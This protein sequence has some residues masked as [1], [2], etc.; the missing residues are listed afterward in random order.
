MKNFLLIGLFTVAVSLF[1]TG[2]AQFLP[3]LENRP[4]A[5][6]ALGSKIGP[7]E[8]SAIGAGVFDANCSQCHKLGE[9]GR[10]PDLNGMGPRAADR[11]AERSAESGQTFTDIDYLVEA[12]CKPGDYLVEGFGNIMPPQG[13]ALSG[14]QLLAVVAY[15]QN[16]GGDATV[17]GTDV[18]P[19]KRFGCLSGGGSAMAGGGGEA[20][21]AA[22]DPVGPPEKVFDAFGCSGCHAT[23]DEERKIGPSLWGVGKRL[24]KGELYDS[25]LAPDA[26]LTP[27]DPPY[28][29]GVMKETLNGNGFYERMTPADIQA[30]VTWLAANKGG[31]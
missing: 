25:I 30:L 21:P 11:A 5:E 1:Y 31:E 7:E 22:K 10:A 24:T 18:D 17:R 29:L 6:V 12:L 4:P 14:G 9:G 3:Q 15:L 13:K 8:L 16:L 19:I 20:E 27:A 28:A 26:Q 2:V 23:E